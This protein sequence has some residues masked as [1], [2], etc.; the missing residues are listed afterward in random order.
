MAQSFKTLNFSGIFTYQRTPT[1]SPILLRYSFS[2][3]LNAK[4]ALTSAW[5]KCQNAADSAEIVQTSAGL[6]LV[7]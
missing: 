1:P 5:E 3:L 7:L 6:A 4:N 2:A